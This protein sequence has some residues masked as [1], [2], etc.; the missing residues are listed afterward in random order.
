MV[1][2]KELKWRRK[3]PKGAIMEPKTF[4]NIV[5]KTMKDLEDKGLTHEAAKDRATKIAGKAYW[6]TAESKFKKSKKEK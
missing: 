1:N 6:Q 4:Q 5:N 2:E 3:Q